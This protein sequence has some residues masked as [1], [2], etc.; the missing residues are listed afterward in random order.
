MNPGLDVKQL[1]LQVVR[2][3][4]DYM[5]MGGPVAEALILGTAAQESGFHS[6]HQVG[7]GPALGLW[8][9]EPDT[10]RDIWDNFLA[11]R[12]PERSKIRTLMI[13]WLSGVDQLGGNLYYACAMARLDYY[14]SPTKLPETVDLEAL[15]TLYKTVYNT[16][17][18]AAST[19]EWVDNY[20]RLVGPFWEVT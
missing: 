3:T 17:G 19:G 4:L 11:F 20:N 13:P 1:G 5:G 8:Q 14:R 6:L 2:P 16:A 15:A 7:G 12:L 10:A 9:M 18:G